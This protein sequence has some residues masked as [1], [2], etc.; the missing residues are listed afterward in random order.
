LPP[1]TGSR[2]GPSGAARAAAAAA[3]H[4]VVRRGV[5]LDRALDAPR[6][7]FSVPARDS[8]LVQELAYG[9]LRRYWTL[10]QRVQP[11][12]GRPPAELVHALLL[13]GAYQL[14]EMGTPAHAA[15]SE[16][17]SACDVLGLRAAK[18]FANAV[19]RALLRAPAPAEPVHDAGF[20]HPAWLR[21]SVQA[22]WP[23][24]WQRVFEAN[25]RR[26][27]MSLRVNARRARRDAYLKSLEASGIAAEICPITEVGLKLSA[28]MP[29]EQL[30]GFNDGSVS[31][32]DCAAQLAAPLLDARA[33]DRVADLCAAPGGK[34]AHILE[35]EPGLL[36][37][38][39]VEKDPD[40]IER[41]N[42]TFARLGL[43]ATVCRADAADPGAWWDGRPFDR[44]LLDAPCSGTGV[45]RRHPD[46]KHLRRASDL[47]SLQVAQLKLLRAGFA[48]LAP[49]GRLLYATCSILPDENDAVVAEFLRQEQRA[50]ALP[51]SAPAGLAR[52]HGWQ[53]LPGVHGDVDGFYYALIARR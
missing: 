13:V 46:I 5:S 33:G 2:S 52:P 28:P 43:A 41:L 53:L 19:L 34:A 31:V 15:V 22:A 48:V 23:D 49:G 7:R 9:T 21:A 40:R 32:Q 29:I 45:I 26:A 8:A 17:V 18:G 11:A 4:A 27:P 24:H 50:F 36:G 16:T 25:N 35:R 51:V 38:V 6:R 30:P 12:L 3:V 20:D 44:V 1:V 47:V 37:L 10:A 39:A 42:S 14:T